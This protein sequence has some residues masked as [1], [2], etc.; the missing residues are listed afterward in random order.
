MDAPTPTDVSPEVPAPEPDGAHESH[1]APWEKEVVSKGQEY[2]YSVLDALIAEEIEERKVPDSEIAKEFN[3][4][5]DRISRAGESSDPERLVEL[6]TLLTGSA[7]G[8]ITRLAEHQLSR[9]ALLRASVPEMQARAN[10]WHEINSYLVERD[11]L[12]EEM[13]TGIDV[14]LH[15]ACLSQSMICKQQGGFELCVPRHACA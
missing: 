13:E 1:K 3:T 5:I 2:I 6:S 9:R 10:G 7:F 8:T 12:K 11:R 15:R 4:L 14:E